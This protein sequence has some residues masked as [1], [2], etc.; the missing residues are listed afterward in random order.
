[1]WGGWAQR[2]PPIVL[3]ETMCEASQ[4]AEGTALFRPTAIQKT[5]LGLFKNDKT[6]LYSSDPH[7]RKRLRNA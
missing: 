2:Y 7:L 1:V 6:P 5:K 3:T 4:A